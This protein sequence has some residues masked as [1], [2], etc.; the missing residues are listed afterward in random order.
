[1]SCVLSGPPKG[2]REWPAT[3]WTIGELGWK[4]AAVTTNW[5]MAA[6][7]AERAGLDNNSFWLHLD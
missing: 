4:G 2:L 6:N 7:L 5:V 1:M 3:G